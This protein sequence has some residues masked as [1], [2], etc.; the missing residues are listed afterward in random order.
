MRVRLLCRVSLVAA[1]ASLSL[2]AATIDAGWLSLTYDSPIVGLQQ[3]AVTNQTG[4]GICSADY[5]ACDSLSFSGWVLAVNFAAGPPALF[6]WDQ[7]DPAT[8]IQPGTYG[9]NNWAFDVARPIAS[10]TF[11]GRIDPSS[12]N[13]FD[14]V[15]NAPA[16]PPMLFLADPSFS[17]TLAIPG[18][19]ENVFY[20]QQEILVGQ[21]GAATVP[22]PS[23]FFLL[24][25]SSWLW[26]RMRCRT[27]FSRR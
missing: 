4:P 9:P 5:P 3:V 11:T 23:S 21:A 16:D 14:P 17:V 22:E 2:P 25:G 7:N 1:L 18:D 20:A 10:I 27:N 15:T 8:T 13:L 26:F 19:F 6:Q 24:L 12:F